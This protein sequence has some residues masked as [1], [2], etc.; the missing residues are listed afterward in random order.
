VGG[1]RTFAGGRRCCICSMSNDKTIW[2]MTEKEVSKIDKACWYVV[3]Y[4]GLEGYPQV[5][6]IIQ[7]VT[8]WISQSLS[9]FVLSNF[10]WDN[11]Y[12]WRR[13]E[14]NY[15]V[16]WIVFAFGENN[17]RQERT[18]PRHDPFKIVLFMTVI[19]SME[20]AWSEVSR[21]HCHCFISLRTELDPQPSGW[22][23]F[24]SPLV[25]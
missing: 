11:I 15:V 17:I 3:C 2:Y 13:D 18:G 16:A 24:L 14:E 21:I 25:R 22:L 23:R 20:P 5:V 7:L 12:Y 19:M 1:K 9:T 4:R 8:V 6:A 10:E